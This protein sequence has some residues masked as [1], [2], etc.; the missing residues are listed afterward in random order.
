MG[1]VLGEDW[2]ALLPR[3]SSIYGQT[4]KANLKSLEESEVV[5]HYHK[6]VF[7]NENGRFALRLPVKQAAHKLGNSKSMAISRFLSV[8]RR[9]QRDQYLRIEY[10]KFM[11]EYLDVGH[12]KCVPYETIIPNRSYYLPLHAVLKTSSLTTKLRVVFDA[13]AKSSSELS[14]HET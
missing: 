2:K 3:K 13:S 4:F 14:L 5:Q 12:M 8:K 1:E 7:R 11:K 9:L 6:T 10:I